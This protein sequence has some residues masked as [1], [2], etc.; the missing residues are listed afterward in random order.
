MLVRGGYSKRI[1]VD[2]K[3]VGRKKKE[4]ERREEDVDFRPQSSIELFRTGSKA[5]MSSDRDRMG[6]WERIM[7]SPEVL[8]LLSKFYLVLGH[9]GWERKEGALDSKWRD[10]A[11]SFELRLIF[12]EADP[13]LVDAQSR[14][15]L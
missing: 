13:F 7:S 14:V 4:M 8:E 6:R 10:P 15:R 3:V 9:G 11:D 1:E 2:W 12:P 5:R